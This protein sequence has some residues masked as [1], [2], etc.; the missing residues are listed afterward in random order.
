MVAM[1]EVLMPML[2]GGTLTAAAQSL[3]LGWETLGEGGGGGGGGINTDR[4]GTRQ[5]WSGWVDSCD[6]ARPV[7]YVMSEHLYSV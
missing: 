5:M 6:L 4:V 1:T 7:G 3:R 2:D